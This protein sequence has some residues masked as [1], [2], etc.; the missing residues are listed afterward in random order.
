MILLKDVYLSLDG[1]TG[2]VDILKGINLEINIGETVSVVGPSGSG[3]TSMMMII[4]GLE[5][6][7]SGHVEING[8]V[9]T[10]L[11]EDAL[12]LFRRDTLGIIFQNFHLVPTM[13]ALE[14]VAIPAE[15]CGADDA[16]D[17]AKKNLELVGL[18]HRIKHYPSQL[19]GGE[20]QRVALAR[21]FCGRPK[22]LLADEPTG[23][24]DQETG[25]KIIDLLFAL[26]T[27]NKTTLMLIT[28]DPSIAE[29]STRIISLEDG[30]IIGSPTL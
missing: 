17:R 18:G 8:R 16:F 15:F 20:Q 5:R 13:S 19:S 9:L 30:K 14:N 1:P 24:L 4:A 3:K 25:R 21:A 26:S 29:K 27:E 28:H 12:S 22:V 7:T 11:S 2:Q 6:A 10:D 23:N